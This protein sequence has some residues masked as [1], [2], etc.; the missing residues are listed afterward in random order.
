M[1]RPVHFGGHRLCPGVKG[2]DTG[3]TRPHMSAQNGKR[4]I[5]HTRH[6]PGRI[7]G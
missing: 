3:L 1:V 4:I 6:D 7:I 5:V 2:N